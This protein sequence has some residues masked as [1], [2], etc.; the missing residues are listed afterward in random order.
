MNYYDI[1][2]TPLGKLYIK[3]SDQA[4]LS[5]SYNKEHTTT[6]PNHLTKKCVQQLDEYFRGKRKTFDLPIHFD[7]TD[8]QVSAWKALLDVP[9]GATSTYL[10]QAQSISNPRAVRAIGGANGKNKISIIVPCHRIIGS[11]GSLTGYGGGLDRKKWLLEHEQ[12]FN[13]K[14]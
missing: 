14:K 5:V 1:Y 6:K 12:K 8:F 10:K 11:D 4:I 2:K 13:T 7:G 9:F 3:A